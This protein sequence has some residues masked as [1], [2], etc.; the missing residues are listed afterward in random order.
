[1]A[2]LLRSTRDRRPAVGAA[3]DR[4]GLD[5]ELFEI[6]VVVPCPSPEGTVK[7]VHFGIAE[8]PGNAFSR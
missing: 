4:Q 8:F 6:A 7:A 5:I 2:W 1:M 3:C